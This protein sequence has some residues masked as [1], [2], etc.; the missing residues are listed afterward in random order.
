MS[1]M[2]PRTPQKRTKLRR[3]ST[4]EQ[5]LEASTMPHAAFLD[6]AD[7]DAH[8]HG[9]HARDEPREDDL[10]GTSGSHTPAADTRAEEPYGELAASA[11]TEG[12][13]TA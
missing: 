13:R 11:S 10:I 1:R 9:E 6:A 8:E 3:S 12:G 2:I 4:P 5:P 7:V